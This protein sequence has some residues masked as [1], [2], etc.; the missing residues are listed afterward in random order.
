[1]IVRCTRGFGKVEHPDTGEELN[2]EDELEVD[3]ETYEALNDA[4]PGFEVVEADSEDETTDEDE[5]SDEEPVCGYNG[6]ER[7]V[8]DPS[9]RCWQHPPDDDG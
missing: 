8:D 5:E 4:Y 3:R 1:M 7:T 2:V 6:C 9:E